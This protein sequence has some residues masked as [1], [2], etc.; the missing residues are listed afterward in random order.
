MK[1]S[2]KLLDGNRLASNNNKVLMQY[3]ID[4]AFSKPISQL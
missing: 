2:F 1:I 4:E 3:I